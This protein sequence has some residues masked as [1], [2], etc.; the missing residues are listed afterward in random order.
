MIFKFH[1]VKWVSWKSKFRKQFWGDEVSA[2]SQFFILSEN[3][4]WNTLVFLLVNRP[5]L[6]L[7]QALVLF[8]KWADL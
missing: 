2:N 6:I 4:S 7:K 8:P 1:L 5:V 3:G